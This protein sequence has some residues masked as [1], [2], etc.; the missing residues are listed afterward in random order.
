MHYEKRG[1]KN[2][3][4]FYDCNGLLTG[5]EYDGVTYY[6]ATTLNGDVVAI[7]DHNGTCLVEY[8]YDA[9]GNCEITKDITDFNLA[10]VNPI[11]YRGYYYD[12]ETGL[13]YLQSRYYDPNTGRFLNSDN[14]TDSNA[15]VLG[16]NTFMYCANNPVNS[17]DPSGHW[18]I[19]NAIKWVA[20]KIQSVADSVERTLSKINLT[21][22]R[23]ISVNASP[24]IWNFNVQ[25]GFSVDTE[26]TV[27]MQCTVAGGV[28]SS[29][30][31]S[32]SVGKYE[33][34]TNA[35]NINKL[36]GTGYQFGGS[37]NAPLPAPIS[38][39]GGG[40]FNIIPDNDLNNHYY[41]ITR[42]AGVAPPI[43]SG[44]GHVE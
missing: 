32:A 28:T 5:L 1:S 24:G 15:G 17:S 19:K 12:R 34:L 42:F 31:P 11:R 39:S 4:Y 33:M 41:G 30:T 25:V 20:T 26:G 10:K 8:E 37:F 23:G 21:Y 44:E 43:M 36:E 29:D 2:I 16:Y 22:S 3:F 14:V 40:E 35:P 6:P 9:L 13:Y 7:Y 27:G 18:I 38:I